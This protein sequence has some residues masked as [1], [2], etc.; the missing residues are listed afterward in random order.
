[1]DIGRLK[2]T[3]YLIEVLGG[4]LPGT[5]GPYRTTHERDC[6]ARALH[7]KQRSDDS[8]FWAWTDITG[9]IEIGYYSGGFFI[10]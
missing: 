9:R 3:H 4:T 7:E 8:L 10:E 2:K 6:A 5:Y 1:M